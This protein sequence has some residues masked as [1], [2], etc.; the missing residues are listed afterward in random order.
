MEHNVFISVPQV[1]HG[2]REYH[3]RAIDG[4][5]DT[6]IKFTLVGTVIAGFEK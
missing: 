2:R 4:K 5:R 1:P 3:A 6:Q